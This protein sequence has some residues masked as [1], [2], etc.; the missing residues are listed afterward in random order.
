MEATVVN[1]VVAFGGVVAWS[2]RGLEALIECLEV[3]LAGLFVDRAVSVTC[4]T[5]ESLAL[6]LGFV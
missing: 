2:G 3:V 6:L 4:S 5:T 1:G